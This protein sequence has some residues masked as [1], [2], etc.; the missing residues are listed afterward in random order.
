MSIIKV[1]S[2][3]TNS[4]LSLE[5]I[6]NFLRIDF[7]DDDVLLQKALNTAT[8][9]CE[10]KIGQTLN[11]K[12]Y[13]MSI[14]NPL[15]SDKIKLRAVMTGANGVNDIS[16]LGITAE[17]IGKSVVLV[18]PNETNYAALTLEKL[19][20]NG[21]RITGLN[22]DTEGNVKKGVKKNEKNSNFIRSLWWWTSFCC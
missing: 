6:K 18:V 10:L 1:I 13:L 21:N 4:I 5:E 7:N 15:T 16:K 3:E 20:I 8:R 9:Q 2:E 12:T 11:P 22:Y 14:Y 17:I 19:D